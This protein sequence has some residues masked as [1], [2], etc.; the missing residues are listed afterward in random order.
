MS[1]DF[2][3]I[4]EEILSGV[5][6]EELEWRENESGERW[7]PHLSKCSTVL[8]NQCRSVCQLAK[9]NEKKCRYP[10][11]QQRTR[12]REEIHDVSVREQ[13]LS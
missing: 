9:L 7:T 12:V 3:N 10:L 2:N 6:M 11:N 5:D 8:T 1:L 4:P 13:T